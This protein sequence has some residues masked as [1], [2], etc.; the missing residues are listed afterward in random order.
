LKLN[1]I[2]LISFEVTL[3]RPP[4]FIP[5]DKV[6][7][8]LNKGGDPMAIA[9]AAAEKAGDVLFPVLKALVCLSY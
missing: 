2:T 5:L 7:D 4:D 3:S 8:M 6:Q 1:G 9:Q